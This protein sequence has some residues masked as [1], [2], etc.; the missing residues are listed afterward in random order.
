[1]STPHYPQKPQKHSSR[2]LQR[3]AAV[4]ADRR[5]NTAKKTPPANA[6]RRSTPRCGRDPP[7]HA[8][9]AAVT[10]PIRGPLAA[11]TAKP[12]TST[13]NA[14]QRV[15]RILRIPRSTPPT[16]HLPQ[17][18]PTAWPPSAVI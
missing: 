16:S 17:G 14:T 12:L 3:H 10:R 7:H 2:R 5:E 6:A 8:N 11:L 4:S 13:T 18:A 1:M 9:S 15:L